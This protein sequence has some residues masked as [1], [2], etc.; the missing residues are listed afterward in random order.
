MFLRFPNQAICNFVAEEERETKGA[1]LLENSNDTIEF[2]EIYD[3]MRDMLIASYE[4]GCAMTLR[5]P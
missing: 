5:P 2:D 3:T 4:V 1:C